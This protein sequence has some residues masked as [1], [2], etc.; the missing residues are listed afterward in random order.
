MTILHPPTPSPLC[1]SCLCWLTEALV[2]ASCWTNHCSKAN[3]STLMYQSLSII[4]APKLGVEW[5]HSQSC[6]TMG[7]F[8]SC[9]R[10][11]SKRAQLAWNKKTFSIWLWELSGSTLLLKKEDP[12]PICNWTKTPKNEANKAVG[13]VKRKKF[14]LVF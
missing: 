14:H 5:S 2:S 4:V 12:Y 6:H 7:S 13:R 1:D 9:Q 3:G 10:I 8:L 11:C